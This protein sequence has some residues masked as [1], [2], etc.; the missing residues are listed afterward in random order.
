MPTDWN[1]LAVPDPYADR[2]VRVPRAVRA[3]VAWMPFAVNVLVVVT[4][5][6]FVVV[7]WLRYGVRPCDL[8]HGCD[9][10]AAIQTPHQLDPLVTPFVMVL[11]LAVVFAPVFAW[12]VGGPTVLVSA[13]RLRRGRT[14]RR[15]ATLVAGTLVLALAV[16]QMTPVG[17]MFD[18]WFLD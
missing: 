9:G 2:E 18:L 6:V 16:F 17:A 8:D 14:A 15:V 13:F 5:A 11:G 7:P 3:T 12:L 4:Y 1:G 10:P